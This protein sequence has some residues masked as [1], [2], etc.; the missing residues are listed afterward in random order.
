RV[1]LYGSL[2]LL[3][4]FGALRLGALYAVA[5][6]TS[7]ASNVFMVSYLAAVKN[8]VEPD[9]VASANGRL[10][11][12]QALTY[13]VGSALAGAVCT[14]FGSA[15]AMGVDA[16]SFGVSAATLAF[17]RFRRDR[18]ERERAANETPWREL[19]D[20]LGFLV[21]EPVLRALTLFQTGVALLGSVGV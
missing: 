6:F 3:A 21:R 4:T 9:E 18:A 12:T 17:V 7:V 15:A 16:L 13:V 8:L 14:R 10:Q 5:F 19:A 1:V 2:P 20:G 11:A